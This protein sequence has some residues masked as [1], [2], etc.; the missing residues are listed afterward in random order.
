MATPT[1]SPQSHSSTLLWFPFTLLS[2]IFGALASVFSKIALVDRATAAGI[3]AATSGIWNDLGLGCGGDGAN[4]LC[5]GVAGIRIAVRTVA[6]WLASFMAG[7]VGID[8]LGSAEESMVLISRGVSIALVVTSNVL[9]W[10]AFSRALARAP[11]TAHATVANT[12]ANLVA[13]AVLSR[14]VFGEPLAA[15]WF[16]GVGFILSG[17]AVMISSEQEPKQKSE[18][19]KSSHTSTAG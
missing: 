2:G 3:V 13:T 4:G 19:A 5:R 15:L 10:W 9:M 6:N 12:A 7:F 16:V 8:D 18:A 11:T 1:S 14:V 17:T